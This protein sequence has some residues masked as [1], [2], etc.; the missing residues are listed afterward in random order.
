MTGVDGER[1]MCADDEFSYTWAAFQA[2]IGGFRRQLRTAV[3]RGELEGDP[4]DPPQ[5]TGGGDARSPS[6][7]PEGR[8]PSGAERRRLW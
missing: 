3:E 8:D 7:S 2:A 6:G 1:G 5:P 4:L